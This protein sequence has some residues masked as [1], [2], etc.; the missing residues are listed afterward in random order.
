VQHTPDD[1]KTRIT[2]IVRQTSI[3]LIDTTTIHFNRSIYSRQF[4]TNIILL[5]FIFH[6]CFLIICN[7][8]SA[9][10]HKEKFSAQSDGFHNF[11]LFKQDAKLATAAFPAL[12]SS[13]ATGIHQGSRSISAGFP[14]T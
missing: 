11:L 8:N 2:G 9:I 1:R 3:L 14:P 5:M 4:I 12:Q 10:F 7:I 13:H 6:Y